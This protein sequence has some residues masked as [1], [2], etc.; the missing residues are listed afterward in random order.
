MD[1]FQHIG[2]QTD[3]ESDVGSVISDILYQGRN[4]ARNATRDY[5]DESTVDEN[6]SLISGDY[7]GQRF[8]DIDHFHELENE[9]NGIGAY[10][11]ALPEHACAYCGIH[12]VSSVVK[13]VTCN[14]WFCNS[15]DG[16]SSSHII[17]HLVRARHKVCIQHTICNLQV[18]S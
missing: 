15:R 12:S 2:H 11:S 17:T 5:D 4:A 6:I 7:G 14:K 3:A 9:E 16:S 13:C 18:F 8:G 10:T 1:N